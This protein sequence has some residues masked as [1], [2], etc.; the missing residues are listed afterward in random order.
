MRKKAKD[1]FVCTMHNSKKNKVKG[2][3]MNATNKKTLS[4]LALIIALGG[5]TSTQQ[6]SSTAQSTSTNKIDI[7]SHEDLLTRAAIGDVLAQYLVGKNHL[8]GSNGA[9]KDFVEAGAWMFLAYENSQRKDIYNQFLTHFGN[10][11]ET[12]I[13]AIETRL[14]QL[15]SKYGKGAINEQFT[16]N[17]LSDAEC[18]ERQVHKSIK[19]VNP[20]YPRA[21]ARATNLKEGAAQVTFTISAQGQV[22]DV[23]T[24]LYT[25][26][27]FMYS[28]L[29]AVYQWSYSKAPMRQGYNLY[30]S[31]TVAGDKTYSKAVEL[32]QN[33]YLE[34]DEKGAEEQFDL[35]RQLYVIRNLLDERSKSEFAYWARQQSPI[36]HSPFEFQEINKWLLKAAQNGH[37]QAQFE[38][39]MNIQNGQGCEAD[40]LKSQAWLQASALQNFLPAKLL[41]ANK[42][43]KST[44][45]SEHK[46]ALDILRQ[47]LAGFSVVPKLELAWHLAASEFSELQNPQEALKILDNVPFEQSDKVRFIETKAAAYAALGKFEDAIDLQIQAKEQAEDLGWQDIP[48]IEF[49]LQQYRDKQVSKGSY[50]L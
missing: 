2:I 45:L 40:P 47:S 39:G 16:P 29:D 20:Q 25:D 28:T 5:C 3:H 44:E 26:E 6:N 4:A 7:S 1:Q 22:R 32:L 37:P 46:V 41:I 34:A 18:I 50:Y 27:H 9:Q 38:L 48:D 43:L 21:L 19:R 36:Q 42:K 11:D 10:L 49:R 17:L 15:K 14:A 23:E 8:N 30:M 13:V 35:S 31:Y 33:K 12:N 24:T